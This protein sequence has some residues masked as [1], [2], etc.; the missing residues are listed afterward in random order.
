MSSA[1]NSRDGITRGSRCD[2]ERS[3]DDY[4]IANGVFLPDF[5]KKLKIAWEELLCPFSGNSLP[6]VSPVKF[7]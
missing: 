5:L 7:C 3:K 6:L 1:I 4:G 2:G